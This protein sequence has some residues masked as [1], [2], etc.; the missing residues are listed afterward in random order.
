LAGIFK[1]DSGRHIKFKIKSTPCNSQQ[2]YNIVP[3]LSS[4]DLARH[5]N[6]MGPAQNAS[7]YTVLDRSGQMRLIDD[8][9]N[10]ISSFYGKSH[11][12]RVLDN[13]NMVLRIGNNS[14]LVLRDLNDSKTLEFNYRIG[15]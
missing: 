9:E 2:R 4:V 8:R 1:L 14:G 15:C 6:F 3:S 13:E 7:R 5:F 11:E 12:T 10:V